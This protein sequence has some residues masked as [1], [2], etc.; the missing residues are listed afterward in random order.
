MTRFKRVSTTHSKTLVLVWIILLMPLMA[1]SQTRTSVVEGL[2]FDQRADALSGASIK[3]LNLDN[4]FEIEMESDSRGHFKRTLL[5]PGF[6]QLTVSLEG[7]ESYERKRFK[8]TKGKRLDFRTEL[9][10]S[11]IRADQ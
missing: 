3:L 5:T 9:K 8:L 10:T 1:H 4:G 2:V 7:Y 11:S 6:Y